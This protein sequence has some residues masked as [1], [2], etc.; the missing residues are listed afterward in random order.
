MT[1]YEFQGDYYHGNPS[2][3]KSTD[4]FHGKPYSEKWERDAAKRSHYE[5][6]GY[7]YVVMWESDWVEIVKTLRSNV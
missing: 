1:V 7:N 6:A 5:A 2:K 4:L 3:F